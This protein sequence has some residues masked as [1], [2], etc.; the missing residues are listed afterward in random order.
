MYNCV[1]KNS[2]TIQVQKNSIPCIFT[3]TEH[4]SH[5]FAIIISD[6]SIKYYKYSF[7]FHRV[8]C[9]D[10]WRYFVSNDEINNSMKLKLKIYNLPSDLMA[11]FSGSKPANA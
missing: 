5:Y 2:I 4:K 8:L 9:F 1:N 7:Y 3:Q 6:D 10:V 11:S